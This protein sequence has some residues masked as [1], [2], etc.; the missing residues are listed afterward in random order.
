MI[1]WS[2]G[3]GSA[4]IGNLVDDFTA[5]SGAGHNA[6]AMHQ[7]CAGMQTHVEAAQAYRQIPDEQAEAS[8][9]RALALYARAASDC[10]AGTSGLNAALIT[11]A[12]QEMD[13]GSKELDQTAARIKQI[14]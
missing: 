10:L 9:A 6:T 8:W 13:Q 11:K 7:A 5:I 3:G 12:G 4:L 2:D 1:G 14:T